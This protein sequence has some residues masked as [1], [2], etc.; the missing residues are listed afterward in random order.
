M[1]GGLLEYIYQALNWRRKGQ[2]ASQAAGSI[3]SGHLWISRM[4][5]P[6]GQRKKPFTH[7]CLSARPG[8]R[9]REWKGCQLSFPLSFFNPSSIAAGGRYRS[10]VT[11]IKIHMLS[12]RHKF[13]DIIPSSMVPGNGKHVTVMLELRARFDEEANLNGRK[14]WRMK[15]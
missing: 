15:G 14:G 11:T 4:C 3:I 7:T 10:K 1:D 2:P 8:S 12:P 13:Q 6:K 9:C 5:S